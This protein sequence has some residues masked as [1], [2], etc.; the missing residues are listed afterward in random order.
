MPTHLI[1]HGPPGVGKTT[2]A[3][4]FARE[5]LA[6][7]FENSF[8]ELRSYDDRSVARIRDG[9]ATFATLPPSRSAPFRV[10]FIDEADELEPK[11]QSA[12]RPAME[13]EGATT[14]FLLACNDLD[15]I[16]KPLQSRC[17]VLEFS[18]LTDEE[19][20]QVLRDAVSIAPVS[21]DPATLES[22]LRRSH[23]IPREGVKLLIEALAAGPKYPPTAVREP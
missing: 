23:G 8:H 19:I 21:P 4:A 15:R 3:R 6:D 11:A 2:A 14:V 5:V 12:L 17:T 10:V 22:I 20:R 18:P 9:I 7:D 16:A 13:G 1:L